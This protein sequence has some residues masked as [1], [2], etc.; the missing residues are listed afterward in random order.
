MICYIR[1]QRLFCPR[2][3]FVTLFLTQKNF[4]TE[5]FA[6]FSISGTLNQEVY[7]KIHAD[8]TPLRSY[9][10]WGC[11]VL[12]LNFSFD[13]FQAERPLRAAAGFLFAFLFLAAGF[14]RTC[15]VG[16]RARHDFAKM[17]AASGAESIRYTVSFS[18]EDITI[19]TNTSGFALTY[20]YEA[21]VR[22]QKTRSAFLLRTDRHQSILVL[23]EHMSRTQEKELISFLK[24]KPTNIRW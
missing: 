15:V 7:R 16:S 21:L 14:V 20:P 17:K 13:N 11:V 8:I 5:D 9:V 19:T 23:R 12:C 18:D 22:I 10:W 6:M 2:H 4:S 1:G 24:G 3:R